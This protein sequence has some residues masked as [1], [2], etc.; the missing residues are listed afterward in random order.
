MDLL[1]INI[2]SYIP[3]I[4]DAY[5]TVYGEKYRR[6][7]TRRL[8]SFVFLP[9]YDLEGLR[10]YIYHMKICKTKEL[11][12]QFLHA[13]G[14]GVDDGKQLLYLLFNNNSCVFEDCLKDYLPLNYFASKGVDKYKINLINYF[15]DDKKITIND[16]EDFIKTDEYRK[17]LKL[18]KGYVLIYNRLTVKYN[19]WCKQFDE[20]LTF[21]DGDRK[22]KK[23]IMDRG[24]QDVLS[25]YK[26][27]ISFDMLVEDEVELS[28]LLF[29]SR[30]IVEESN[31]EYFGT[32]YIDMLENSAININ[33]KRLI[34]NRQLSYLQFMGIDCSKFNNVLSL[35]E[36]DIKE[37]LEFIKLD[38]VKASIPEQSLIEKLS[39]YRIKKAEECKN[40]Y[41]SN[42]QDFVKNNKYF[43][44][45]GKKRSL[46]LI[47]SSTICVFDGGLVDRRDNTFY[48][49]LFFSTVV[50]SGGILDYMFV[51]EC[52][53]IID[54]N[55][56]GCGFVNDKK[57][58]YKKKN[59]YDDK[60][61][62]YERFNE[63]INDIFTTKVVEIL[64][65]KG[66]YLFDSK[67]F[68]ESNLDDCNSFLVV[69]NMLNRLVNKFMRYVIEAKINA[70]SSILSLVIGY[71]NFQELVDLVNYVD[72]LARNGLQEYLKDNVS[73]H[74]VS[75]YYKCLDELDI[76]YKKVDAYCASLG[77][78]SEIITK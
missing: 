48:S 49:A 59:D 13:I 3:D 8:N 25:F 39:K 11:L 9:Y 33:K 77:T 26:D 24:K 51:H 10:D 20:C 76:V 42:R 12:A 60:Y 6:D 56:F 73:N 47:D 52:G 32:K 67:S 57:I 50:G 34:I 44:I 16:Y 23:G 72:Y 43:S 14:K 30:S 2:D 64:R 74:I 36:E 18:V 15:L 54:N 29:N 38:N 62:K 17:I 58:D 1:N 45:L 41:Y 4:V 5:T 37:Y 22:R 69:K 19:K 61:F 40:E 28:K 65:N 31:I 46:A 71:D 7:I 70:D 27:N 21:I 53:H 68:A 55:S 35:S 66:I 78:S 63:A 75:E